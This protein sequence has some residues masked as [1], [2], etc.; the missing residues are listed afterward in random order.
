MRFL[1]ETCKSRATAL[2]FVEKVRDDLAEG[3]DTRH[4]EPRGAPRGVEVLVFYLACAIG[5]AE[6][7]HLAQVR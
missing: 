2:E 6:V 5:V 7:Q 4:D 1:L 3:H